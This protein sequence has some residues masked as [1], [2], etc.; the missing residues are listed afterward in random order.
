M[1]T[2]GQV[3]EKNAP[4][5]AKRTTLPNNRQFRAAAGLD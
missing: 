2:H 3:V 1:L 4:D 5:P